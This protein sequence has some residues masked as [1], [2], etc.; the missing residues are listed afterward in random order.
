MNQPNRL[1]LAWPML[2]AVL[3]LS[4]C[5]APEPEEQAQSLEERVE[6]RWQHII[7]RDFDAA[8]PFYSPGFRETSPRAAFVDDMQ[9]RPVSYRNAVF[10]RA[11]CD[12]DRCLVSVRV[13]YQV[14]GGPSSVRDMRVPSTVEERWIRLD[15]DWWFAGQ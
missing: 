1:F 3:L 13:T 15:G 10:E 4:A 6:A 2:A 14:V 12:G 7:D 11:E 5:G 9:R 8:W